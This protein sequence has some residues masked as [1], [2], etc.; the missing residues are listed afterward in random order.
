MT[1]EEV[2]ELIEE[3]Y[4]KPIEG[5]KKIFIVNRAESINHVAQNKLLKTLEEPPKGVHIIM[6]ATNEHAL[7][8]TIKSR[9]KKYIFST[10]CNIANG[11]KM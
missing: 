10:I 5:D 8:P 9:V 3:S 11:R 7:L 6:G 1:S 2:N 4:L